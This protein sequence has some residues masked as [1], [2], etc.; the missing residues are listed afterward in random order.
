MSDQVSLLDDLDIT[1]P[2]PG[3]VR[4][5][6]PSTSRVAAARVAFKTGALKHRILR[7]LAAQG[8]NGANDWELHVH[9]D[10]TGRVHSAATRR[11]ELAELG[12]V[13][14]T[15]IERPTDTPGN[16]GLV[17]VLTQKGLE[18]LA[19]ADERGTAA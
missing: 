3:R 19:Q 14:T 2:A 6:D 8:A 1:A 18:V 13:R 9:C 15:A 5:T 11:K 4:R 7:Y 17:S 12:L 10:P 16:T